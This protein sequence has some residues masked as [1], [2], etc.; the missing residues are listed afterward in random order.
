MHPELSRRD[1]LHV[2]S[3]LASSFAGCSSL[4][5]RTRVA[6]SFLA[7]PGRG[8]YGPPLRALIETVL[9]IGAAD[10]PLQLPSVEERFLRM[11]PL[12]NER[13]FLGLQ[14]TLMFFE[15]LDLAP[16]VAAPLLASERIALDVPVRVSEAEFRRSCTN[17][18]AAESAA[19]D[20][21]FARHGEHA[22]FSALDADARSAWLEL[23]ASSQFTVK[24][25]FASSVRIIL[26]IA[27]YSSDRMWPIIGYDGPLVPGAERSM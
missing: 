18:I 15:E 24:R 17:K 20:A 19:C 1:F 23:W 14:R 7:D 2:C 9:P 11:F 25:D 21:F 12:E 16:H 4:T 22:R 10:F 27:A 3:V 8:D 5:T 26:S 13:Q 6:A